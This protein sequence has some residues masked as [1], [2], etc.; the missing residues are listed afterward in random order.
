MYILLLLIFKHISGKRRQ[1]GPNVGDGR[2]EVQWVKFY[3]HHSNTRAMTGS[4]LGT[5]KLL[6][7]WKTPETWQG[8][9]RSCSEGVQGK[10]TGEEHKNTGGIQRKRT[11]PK[12]Q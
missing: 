8:Q 2:Q 3:S 5:G 11:G 9:R 10:Q 6:I 12:F 4:T 7:G 1:D